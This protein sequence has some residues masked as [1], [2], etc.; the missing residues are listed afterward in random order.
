MVLPRVDRHGCG[1]ENMRGGKAVSDVIVHN[2]GSLECELGY[3]G[4][5]KQLML[6]STSVQ[7]YIILWLKLRVVLHRGSEHSPYG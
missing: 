3:L 4:H 7:I 5:A 1:H 2:K 6:T